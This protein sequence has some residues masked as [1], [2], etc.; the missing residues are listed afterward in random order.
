[1]ENQTNNA[2]IQAAPK[3]NKP[4]IIAL[5]AVGVVVVIGIVIGIFFAI[6]GQDSGSSVKYGTT[7][8]KAHN[9]YMDDAYKNPSAIKELK[10]KNLN[11]A[12]GYSSDGSKIAVLTDEKILSVYDTT[13]L[14]PVKQIENIA[15]CSKTDK[16]DE[17]ACSV[18]TTLDNKNNSS[19]TSPSNDLL[20][21]TNTNSK[22]KIFSLDSL[23]FSGTDLLSSLPK[24]NDKALSNT[25]NSI[26]FI[27][28]DAAGSIWQVK[29]SEAFTDISTLSEQD[30]ARMIGGLGIYNVS[31]QS[32]LNIKEGKIAWIE[33]INS[34]Q[35]TGCGIADNNSKIL[36]LSEG[37][38]GG[39]STVRVYDQ[40]SGNELFSKEVTGSVTVTNQGWVVQASS[41]SSDI[42]FSVDQGIELDTYDF[43]GNKS[44]ARGM[45][46]SSI[47]GPFPSAVWLNDTRVTYD[48]DYLLSSLNDRPM[49]NN[50][51]EIVAQTSVGSDAV[52]RIKSAS[53]YDMV[54]MPLAMTADGEAIAVLD[55]PQLPTGNDSRDLSSSSNSAAITI[56]SLKSKRQITKFTG[57][58]PMT[59]QNGTLWSTDPSSL[60]MESGAIISKVFVAQK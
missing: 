18:E 51:G 34:D 31:H 21:A 59:L 11:S 12:L 2:P 6:K 41:I 16:T 3:N 28:S 48:T 22:L 8:I 45:F 37:D 13:T 44:S 35:T 17:L 15:S 1:M 30:R 25:I 4:M 46:M 60:D 36:C 54:G 33:E 10:V 27:S 9:A 38:I 14:K 19:S 26:D 50:K 24:Q 53:G 55:A 40:K 58:Q 39:P 47:S 32:L 57:S 56:Q 42:A 43:T 29:T 7:N 52:Q 5:I 49:V 20:S 23:S